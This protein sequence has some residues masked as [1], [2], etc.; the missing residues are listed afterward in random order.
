MASRDDGP[1]FVFMSAYVL[2]KCS[3]TS[4]NNNYEQNIKLFS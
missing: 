4:E 2:N 3:N 1:Q